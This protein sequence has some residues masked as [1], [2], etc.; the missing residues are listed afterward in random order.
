MQ[1]SRPASVFRLNLEKVSNF[2]A[3]SEL[4]AAILVSAP[5]FTYVTGAVLTAQRDIPERLSFAVVK[6][7]KSVT[8][9]ICSIDEPQFRQESN[10][11]DVET[12]IEGELTPAGCLAELLERQGLTGGRIG[13]EAS[14]MPT[15]AYL[16]L[17]ENG[18]G[19]ELVAI[20]GELGECRAVKSSLELDQIAKGC[21]ATAQALYEG[22]RRFRLGETESRLAQ[23]IEDALES[24]GGRVQLIN[25]VS[26][27][28]TLVPNALA[29]PKVI[30]R[31]A[32][33]KVDLTGT[34]SGYL[35]DMARVFYVG[36]A[37]AEQIARYRTYAGV[38]KGIVSQ[39]SVE[40][41][42][43]GIYEASVQA[44][45]AHGL[46]FIAPHVGHGIG[47]ALHD[48]PL[49]NPGNER[50]LSNGMAL[51]VEPR[52]LL[53]PNE[54]AHLEDIL[55]LRDGEVEVFS[56]LELLDEEPIIG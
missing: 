21:V 39:V 5:S 20:D 33:V 15:S 10:V 27:E 36:E 23:H 41:T 24:L 56:P 40:M 13:I 1:D 51:A 32:M 2:V 14:A 44:H 54:R 43:G 22:V 11:A 3:D 6:A 25:V 30:D 53:A 55:L 49:L 47:L 42:A 50:Q 16:E 34:F 12:Y 9:V 29:R 46:R 19:Q 28:L 7:D 45:A 31:G 4:A 18:V 48:Q 38:Y 8:A 17:V 26:G 35:S 37:S 52:C